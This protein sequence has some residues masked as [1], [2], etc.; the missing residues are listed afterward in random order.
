MKRDGGFVRAGASAPLDEARALRDESRRVIAEMQARYADETGT[1]QLKIKHNNFLGYYIET[2]QAQGEALVKPPLNATFIHRQTMAGAMRF[3]T[4]ALI[5]LEIAHRLGGRPRAGA[6]AR[7][8]RAAA[9]EALARER[10]AARRSAR[11]WPKSTSPRRSPNWRSSAIWSRPR[12]DDS[13]A[14]EIDDGRHPVVEAALA[15]ARRAVRRQRLRS[16]RRARRRAGGWRWSPAPTW[17]ANRPSCAR[18]R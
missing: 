12:V 18:T 16:L 15:G 2:P 6:R 7:R 5:E 9:G 4:N 17:R 11:R 10:D 3:T 14:F 8:V 1:R 13:L